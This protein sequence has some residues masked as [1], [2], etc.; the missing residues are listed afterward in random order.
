MRKI[1]YEMISNF[2][3]YLI[4]EEKSENTVE[5]YIR[6]ISFFMPW[7][8][9]REV[10]K[11]EYERLLTAA[12]NKKNERLYYLIQT[13]A[14]TGIHKYSIAHLISAMLYLLSLLYCNCSAVSI[15][16]NIKF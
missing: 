10:T 8:C 15:P 12:K 9:G 7:L 16:I 4:E 2:K 13:T 11:S 5:K 14:S 1:T 6:D 3:E